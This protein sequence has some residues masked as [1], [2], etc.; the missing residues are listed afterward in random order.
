MN[1]TTQ[2][3]TLLTTEEII[4]N[5]IKNN[6]QQIVNIPAEK[7]HT[8]FGPIGAVYQV[9]VTNINAG[10][11]AEVGVCHK[12]GNNCLGRKTIKPHETVTYSEVFMTENGIRVRNKS[13]D[14][15][16]LDPMIRVSLIH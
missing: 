8:F 1:T 2:K 9:K 6:A 16:G 7:S 13:E 3:E 5:S 11:T 14:T 15:I 12:E 4:D 10:L